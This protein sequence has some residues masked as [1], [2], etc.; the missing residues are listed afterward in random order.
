LI[1]HGAGV[2]VAPCYEVE[3][4]FDAA[5]NIL[6]LFQEASLRSVPFFPDA[7]QFAL[8]LSRELVDELLVPKENI[9][10]PV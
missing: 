7:S 2:S 9:P 8:E 6:Q 1:A 4:A 5:L 10:Q 3:A